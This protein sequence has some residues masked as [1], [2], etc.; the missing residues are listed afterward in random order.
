[1]NQRIVIFFAACA[2]VCHAQSQLTTIP[3]TPAEMKAVPSETRQGKFKAGD[4]APDFTLKL[5]H[6]QSSVTLS[7][8]RTKKPVAL[9]FGSYT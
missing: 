2:L 7:S 3:K 4:P 1:M 5:R 9:I 8:F 6:S